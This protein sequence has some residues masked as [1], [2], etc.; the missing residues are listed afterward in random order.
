MPTLMEKLER[1]IQPDIGAD[2]YVPR[3]PG[4]FAPARVRR[5]VQYPQRGGAFD[6]LRFRRVQGRSAERFKHSVKRGGIDRSAV[7]PHNAAYQP[8]RQ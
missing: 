7:Q 8:H 3:V 1:I 5:K 4:Q 6:P 2:P